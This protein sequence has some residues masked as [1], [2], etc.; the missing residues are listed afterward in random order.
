MMKRL[1]RSEK[2]EIK[3]NYSDNLIFEAI[4]APCKKMEK[5]LASFRLS[6]EEVFLECLSII[7]DL[8]ECE[9]TKQARLKVNG[10]WD[11]IYCDFRDL[12]NEDTS[13]QELK[14]AA[15]EVVAVT[16]LLLNYCKNRS[17]DK[18]LIPLISQLGNYQDYYYQIQ[19]EFIPNFW[20][21]GE[22]EL[23]DYIAE[24]WESDD[25]ISD[26]IRG[27]LAELDVN[28]DV[29]DESPNKSDVM[30][31]RQLA[32]LFQQLLNVSFSTED[33]N[34]SALAKLISRVSGRSEGG[35]RAQI[36]NMKDIDYSEKNVAADIEEVAEL[37]GKISNDV[38]KRHAQP[39]LNNTKIR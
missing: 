20:T 35:V 33:T 18:L 36:N 37:L 9:S 23:K 6:A 12:A 25:Y 30:T 31:N 7:D 29:A 19:L 10:L 16:I 4:F 22:D 34:I 8:K 3:R 1:R 5:E 38:K 17:V 2:E 13:E 14:Q 24:Y 11:A 26:S 21:V 32:I 15:S 28:D 27:R 39:L